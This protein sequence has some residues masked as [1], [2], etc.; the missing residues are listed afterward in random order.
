[1]NPI[2]LQATSVPSGIQVALPVAWMIVL[3]LPSIM[4]LTGTILGSLAL[5]DI[6]LANGKLGGAMLA[7]L[8]AG[9]LP[10][11]IITGF[12][13]GLLVYA[14]TLI[15]P[16]MAQSPIYWWWGGAVAGA[17]LSYIMLRGMYRHATGWVPPPGAAAA[18]RSHLA[19]AAIVLTIAGGGLAFLL[20]VPSFHL[21]GDFRS[22]NVLMVVTLPILLAGLICG[23]LARQ[24]KSGSVCAWIC[25]VLFVILVLSHA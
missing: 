20:I 18:A 23:V 22:R 14:V 16:V 9:L 1:M 3:L 4:L 15:S 24:E 10:A 25:G 21:F 12:C 19:T 5:R 13:G 2:L 11:C 17:W 7:T 8:A 6:R